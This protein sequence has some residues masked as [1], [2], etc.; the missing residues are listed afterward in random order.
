MEV[1]NESSGPNIT[2]GRMRIVSANAARTANS[3]RHACGCRAMMRRNRSRFLR[4]A[5]TAP[6]GLDAPDLLIVEQ[7][8]RAR[9]EKSRGHARRIGLPHSQRR[10]RQQVHRRLTAHR[11]CWPRPSEV[12]DH[13]NQTAYEPDLMPRRNPNKKP[14]LRR[15]QTTRRPRN[16]VPPNTTMERSCMVAMAQIR[17]LTTEQPQCVQIRWTASRAN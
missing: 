16:P 10:K 8:R 2:A 12:A 17:L 1:R 6:L 15:R 13:Q 5:R 4:R 11:E 3:P 9:N 14:A 7:P